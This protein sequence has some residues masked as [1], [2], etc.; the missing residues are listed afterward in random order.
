MCTSKIK[1]GRKPTVSDLMDLI[2]EGKFYRVQLQGIHRPI[3][4][5]SCLHVEQQHIAK[6]Q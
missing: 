1:P 4:S 5:P 2:S 3:L 6:D